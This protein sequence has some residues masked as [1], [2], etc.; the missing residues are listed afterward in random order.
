MLVRLNLILTQLEQIKTRR[1]F[2]LN[3]LIAEKKC[4]KCW[5]MHCL[6]LK[7]I[8]S[9]SRV[10]KSISWHLGFH[11]AKEDPRQNIPPVDCWKSFASSKGGYLRLF[12]KWSVSRLPKQVASFHSDIGLYCPLIAKKWKS[13][14]NNGHDWSQS[15]MPYLI[16]WH[17]RTSY[18]SV[19]LTL[20]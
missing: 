8:H 10:S 13:V 18:P 1:K 6:F 17:L 9:S 11:W 15:E 3:R 14:I 19:I 4:Y 7:V 12:L 2:V 5:L 16:T 20:I